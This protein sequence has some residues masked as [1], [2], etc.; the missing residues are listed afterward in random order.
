MNIRNYMTALHRRFHVKS[1]QT[2]E[3]GREV[4]SAYDA[5]HDTLSSEQ[6]KLLLHFLDAEETFRDAESLDAFISGFR[7]ADGIHRELDPPYSYEAWARE[8]IQQEFKTDEQD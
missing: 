8:I 7:L 1:D 5:L 2:E 4:E 3:L 6:Q